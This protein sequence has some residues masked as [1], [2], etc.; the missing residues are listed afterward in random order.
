[1]SEKDQASLPVPDPV[2]ERRWRKRVHDILEHVSS[3]DP[4]SVI[5]NSGLVALILL[6]VT[7]FA[8]ETVP[9]IGERYAD[10]FRVFN[11]F[12]VAVFSIEYVA[13]LWSCLEIHLFQKVKPMR[14]RIRFA[15]RPLLLVDLM[16]ILPFY[17]SFL[18][19]ID[20]RILRV[21]RLFR[22]LKLARYSP[23]LYSLA[24]VITNEWRAL[25]GALLVMMALLLFASTGIYF[26]ER[27]VQ[28]DEFGSIP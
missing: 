26:I 18:L 19:A 23:A 5:V 1:M 15:L 2:P 9:A 20:L 11:I 14:A 17:L 4:V 6:N 10:S 22:F 16:A 13:R 24:R 25:T 8:A 21:L 28:P 7:A 27:N 12:S 3:D